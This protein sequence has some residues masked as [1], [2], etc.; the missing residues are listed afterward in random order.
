MLEWNREI[1]HRWEDGNEQRRARRRGGRECL[2][3]ESKKQSK[4]GGEQSSGGLRM[5]IRGNTVLEQG[6][7][8][9]RRH[10]EEGLGG[11]RACIHMIAHA[12][13]NCFRHGKPP[14]QLILLCDQLQIS[15]K[16]SCSDNEAR[17]SSHHIRLIANCILDGRHNPLRT[18][19]PRFRR[20]PHHPDTLHSLP[21]LL[22]TSISWRSGSRIRSRRNR[23]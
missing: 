4:S 8:I 12:L 17:R 22:I 23:L 11:E 2:E 16:A 5:V 3:L 6:L 10:R 7:S 19:L 9:G 13:F 1:G 18:P 14:L 15:V 20:P 21:F